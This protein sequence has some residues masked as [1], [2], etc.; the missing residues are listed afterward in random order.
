MNS[1]GKKAAIDMLLRL[2]NITELIFYLY[3]PNF[4]CVRAD[5]ED[6]AYRSTVSVK[7][8]KTD[9]AAYPKPCGYKLLAIV[10]FT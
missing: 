9:R 5:I 1:G 10:I 3:A 6:Q 4:R 2:K 7:L 8:V